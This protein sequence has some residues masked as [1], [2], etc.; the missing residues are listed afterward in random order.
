MKKSKGEGDVLVQLM[1]IE[2]IRVRPLSVE[3]L[4]REPQERS[5][6]GQCLL[7]EFAG[8]GGVHCCV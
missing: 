6:I 7:V 8:G 1:I 5:S 4:L 2:H 3:T